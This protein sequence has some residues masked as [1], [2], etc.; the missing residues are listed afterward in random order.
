MMNVKM[1][2]NV[3]TEQNK[4][5]RIMPLFIKKVTMKMAFKLN[6]DIYSS[7][8][9][10]N[11]G[12]VELPEELEQHVTRIDFMLGPP[13]YNKVACACLTYKG[14]V[15]I[16]FTR[17]IKEATVERNFFTTLVKMGIPVK[18]ESNQRY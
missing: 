11:L 16:N 4:L 14:R 6:G 10:S 5:I 12:S 8:T 1:T 17:S 7:T 2:T 3:R 15:R 9:L 13:S 18:I